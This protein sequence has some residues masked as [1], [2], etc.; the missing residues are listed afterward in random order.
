MA[1]KPRILIVT[2]EGI[3]SKDM[4]GNSAKAGGLADVS[5]A[6]INAL[7]DLNCDV[8]VA[9]PDYGLSSIFNGPPP[10]QP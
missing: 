5:A 8:H 10:A 1:K 4:E 9:L 6:L 2:P 7:F 3:C